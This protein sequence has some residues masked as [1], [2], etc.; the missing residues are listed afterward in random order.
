MNSKTRFT[1]SIVY[2]AALLSLVSACDLKKS[3]PT[4]P[5]PVIEPAPQHK[6]GNAGG[7][8]TTAPPASEPSANR[9]SDPDGNVTCWDNAG[10][11]RDHCIPLPH[12]YDV[13][14]RVAADYPDALRSSCQDHGG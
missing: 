7:D 13:V 4:A 2:A 12:L 9:A 14:A 8:D 1:G 10:N 5:A 3:T 11:H 6:T